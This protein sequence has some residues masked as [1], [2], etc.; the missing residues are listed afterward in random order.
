M[1]TGDRRRKRLLLGGQQQVA[2]RG[3]EGEAEA[4]R[5]GD[6]GEEARIQ[7]RYM[8]MHFFRVFAP[9]F[10]AGFL[11]ICRGGKMRVCT[12]KSETTF[13]RPNGLKN[14][15]PLLVCITLQY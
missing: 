13:S 5:G 9:L 11:K 1:F 2:E 6:P 4:A 10:L 8:F 12:P 14:I 7:A 3:P 15:A